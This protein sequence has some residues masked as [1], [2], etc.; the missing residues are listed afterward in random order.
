MTIFWII[1]AIVIIGLLVYYLKKGKQ[2]PKPPEK[3]EAPSEPSDFPEP[4]SE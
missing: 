4:P 2:A 3:P 1:V